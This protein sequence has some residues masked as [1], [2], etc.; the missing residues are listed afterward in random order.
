MDTDLGEGVVFC[1][2]G[3]GWNDHRN[4][5][6]VDVWCRPCFLARMGKKRRAFKVVAGKREGN[7]PLREPRLRSEECMTRETMHV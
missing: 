5:T 2:V 7:R 6:V 4:G 1:G 3:I